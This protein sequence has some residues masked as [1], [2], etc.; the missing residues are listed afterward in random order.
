MMREK[1]NSLDT[2]TG[3]GRTFQFNNHPEVSANETDD[4][5]HLQ[6]TMNA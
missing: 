3:E 4:G 6:V 1:A 2:Y 5:F